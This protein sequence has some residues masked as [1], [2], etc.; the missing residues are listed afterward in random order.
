M[1]K[2][3]LA[4]YFVGLGSPPMLQDWVPLLCYR[5]GSSAYVTVTKTPYRL[6]VVTNDREVQREGSVGFSLSYEL[7]LPD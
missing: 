6:H 1:E 7:H 3:K 4:I 5:L 2:H